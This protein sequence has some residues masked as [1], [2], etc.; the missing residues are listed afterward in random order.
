MTHNQYILLLR[1]STLN[2]PIPR[3]S[4]ITGKPNLARLPGAISESTVVYCEDI[5]LQSR[6]EGFVVLD[7]DVEGSS[8][9]ITME[10][11]DSRVVFYGGEDVGF[12]WIWVG[13][14]WGWDGVVEWVG[15]DEPG[16]ESDVVGG[17]KFEV[18]G[19]VRCEE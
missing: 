9:G 12:K 8:C 16:S 4:S 18:Q 17:V 15:Q 3:C 10:K 19:F 1:P 2:Q 11:K 6:R 13:E 14:S 5:G 7:S